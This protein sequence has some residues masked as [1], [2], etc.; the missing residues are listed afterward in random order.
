M[1]LCH[2]LFVCGHFFLQS[3]NETVIRCAGSGTDGLQREAGPSWVT[4]PLGGVV[5]VTGITASLGPEKGLS[6][7]LAALGERGS[8]A[9]HRMQE[10]RHG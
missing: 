9:T 3:R 2:P 4:E 7:L 1:V 10:R 8:C 5:L 6:G